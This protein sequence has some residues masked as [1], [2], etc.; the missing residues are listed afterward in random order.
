MPLRACQ[1]CGTG[2]TPRDIRQR[3]C[4]AHQPAHADIASPT[5]RSRVPAALRRQVLTEEPT[6]WHQGCTAPSEHVDHVIPVASGGSHDRGNLRGSCQHH[7]LSRGARPAPGTIAEG[8]SGAAPS[9]T[10][11]PRALRVA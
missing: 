11:S 6:C 5:T 7:N 3:H 9:A 8:A 1:T 4:P 2:Y 10:P